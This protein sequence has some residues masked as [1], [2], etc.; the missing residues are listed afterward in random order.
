MVLYKASDHSVW[1]LDIIILRVLEVLHIGCN[2]WTHDLPYMYALSYWPVALGL[3][4]YIYQANPS[5]P[6]YNLYM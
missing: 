6:Y 2:M 4:A 5:C 3:Q 1:S